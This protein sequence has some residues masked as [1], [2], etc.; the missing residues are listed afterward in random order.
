MYAAGVQLV[1]LDAENRFFKVQV[2]LVHVLQTSND[3]YDFRVWHG[4]YK[5]AVLYIQDQ[6]GTSCAGTDANKAVLPWSS[7]M[8][9]HGFRRNMPARRR[10][11]VSRSGNQVG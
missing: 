3:D 10:S 1:S 5:P 9:A 7:L 4:Y 8:R 2:M 6:A 11:C